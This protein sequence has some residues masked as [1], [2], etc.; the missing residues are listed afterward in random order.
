MLKVAV[1]ES[2]REVVVSEIDMTAA[3]PAV[4]TLH[5]KPAAASAC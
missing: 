1:D 2:C 4:H 3:P 5:P